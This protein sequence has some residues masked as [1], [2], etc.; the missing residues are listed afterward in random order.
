M[1][2]Q[3]RQIEPMQFYTRY[4]TMILNYVHLVWGQN[5]ITIKRLN[6]LHK[7]ALKLMNFK[8]RNFYISSLFLSLNIFELPHEIFLENWL[9]IRKAINNFLL[10]LFN[11]CFMFLSET[12]Q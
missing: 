11:S 9:L 7:K 10:S 2:L 1:R 4:R 6:I 5:I 12:C 8:S 3:Q